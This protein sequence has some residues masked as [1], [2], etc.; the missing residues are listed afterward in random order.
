MPEL[1]RPE[2][3]AA[4]LAEY[5]STVLRRA[6]TEEQLQPIRA[7]IVA[8]VEHR[9]RKVE[10]GR[11]EPNDRLYHTHGAGTFQMVIEAGCFDPQGLRDMFAGSRYRELCVEHFN[12]DEFYVNFTRLGFR[13][14]DPNLSDRSFLPYHQDGYGDPRV[15]KVL[16]CWIP[17]DPGCG[18]EAPGLEVVRRPSTANFPLKEF[19][20]GKR[21]L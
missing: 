14:H 5:G 12:D 1:T 16:N 2:S 8:F 9:R 18:R 21:G 17:L 19:G 3:A 20:L 7:A 15:A 4:E 10:G 11:A 6:W 13:A